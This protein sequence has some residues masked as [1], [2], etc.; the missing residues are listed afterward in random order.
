MPLAESPGSHTDP[1]LERCDAV[2]Q[3]DVV[4]HR[5]ASLPGRGPKR[6]WRPMVAYI[7]SRSGLLHS[8][9]PPEPGG[10]SRANAIPDAGNHPSV[11]FST[12]SRTFALEGQDLACWNARSING[13]RV[14]HKD[15]C[16]S[17][18]TP[19][20][21]SIILPIGLRAKVLMDMNLGILP[22]SLGDGA[23]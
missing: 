6:P 3:A 14:T 23:R 2:L 18:W 11:K 17:L 15:F 4:P 20:K 21:E 1:P 7:P 13:L 10:P 9:P 22:S 8:T 5:F 19:L 16:I 12:G